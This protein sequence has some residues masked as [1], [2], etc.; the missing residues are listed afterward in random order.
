MDIE[1]L[2]FL[3]FVQILRTRRDTRA[4]RETPGDVVTNNNTT[5]SSRGSQPD[6]STR[7]DRLPRALLSFGFVR[8]R[9][10]AE[11]SR[12]ARFPPGSGRPYLTRPLYLLPV[13]VLRSHRP[14]LQSVSLFIRS[15]SR[16]PSLYH[17]V[18]THRNTRASGRARARAR[19][20][21]TTRI[22]ASYVPGPADDKQSSNPRVAH[23]AFLFSFAR[24]YLSLVCFNN[25][26][27]HALQLDRT[28]Q[29]NYN[30]KFFVTIT[31]PCVLT[32]FAIFASY[33][34]SF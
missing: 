33:C 27:G 1:R 8:D 30:H 10:G 19:Y 31:R 32:T 24:S 18:K 2:F 17:S 3:L 16:T 6:S 20:S 7:E 11:D 12:T 9:P 13:R 14:R 4:V 5:D 15:G 21:S 25:I 34:R 22:R 26:E 23:C 29:Y 28:A